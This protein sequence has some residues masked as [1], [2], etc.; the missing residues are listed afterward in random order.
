MHKH[1]AILPALRAGLLST[2][3][4]LLV[5]CGGGSPSPPAPALS[6]AAVPAQTV[7]Q[8]SVVGPLPLVISGTQAAQST[9]SGSATAAH[10]PLVP[11]GNVVVGG[12]GNGSTLTITPDPDQSGTSAVTVTV[13]DSLGRQA[14]VT[15][16]L[17]VTPVYE[18]FTQYADTAF[19]TGANAM[20]VPV[21]GLTFV[22]DADNNANA[23]S[24]LIQ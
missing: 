17:T 2:A 1:L 14:T 18:S 20:P 10:P 21:S 22:P 13:A 19:A 7:R 8:G 3:G 6:V 15:F 23:F 9:I 24:A 16:E 4:L 11:A 5:A 12:L